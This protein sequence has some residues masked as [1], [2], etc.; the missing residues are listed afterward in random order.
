MKYQQNYD[1]LKKKSTKKIIEEGPN[2]F[3]DKNNS[4]PPAAGALWGF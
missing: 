3:S 2:Y 4:N 1:T